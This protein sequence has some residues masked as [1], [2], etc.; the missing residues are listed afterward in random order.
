M[1]LASCASVVTRSEFDEREQV[2]ARVLGFETVRF[3]GD[4]DGSEFRNR[5]AERLRNEIAVRGRGV[6]NGGYAEWLMLSG[7]GEDGAFGAGVLVG[8]TKMN[9]RRQYELVSGVSTGALIAPFAFLGPD[10]DPSLR[11]VYTELG[12][13]DILKFAGIGS[14]I[15][16]TSVFDTAPLRSV[17]AKHV[18]EEFL[19]KVA[20]EHRKGRRLYVVTT[21]LDAQR[22]VIWDMGAIAATNNPQRAE[23]FHSVL[24]ASA[25]IPGVF[26]PVFIDADANGRKVQ[27]MHVDGGTTMQVLTLPS[28]IDQNAPLARRFDRRRKT[29]Y[30]LMNNKMSP[31]FD[32][33][34]TRTF[35]IAG[36]S[37]STIIKAHGIQSIEI[38]YELARRNGARFQLT[39]IDPDFNAKLKE[40]FDKEYMGALF[41]YGYQRALNGRVWRDSPPGVQ[42]P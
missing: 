36:R 37:L 22:P 31:S 1:A 42:R 27:E 21:N 5:L 32:R 28:T 6:L 11:E 17:I 34:Q 7:G 41:E 12:K 15:S 14:I 23:L 30:M 29:L 13:D 16:G 19:N 3:Y 38:M 39:Y 35:S 25:S 40:P 26:P 8:M 10:Y 20:A 33:V 24:L 18:D 9:Q 2:A 4:G